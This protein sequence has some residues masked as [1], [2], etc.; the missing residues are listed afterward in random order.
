MNQRINDNLE[1]DIKAF[2]GATGSGKTYSMLKS[3]PTSARC[4]SFDPAGSVTGSGTGFV[5]TASRTEY[6]QMTR[7]GGNV[8]ACF[9]AA[10]KENF[11]WW[12]K[13][14]FALADARRIAYVQVDELSAVTSSSKAP[15]GWN[16]ILNLGRKYGLKVRAGAQRPQEIDK[17]LIGNQNGIWIGHQARRGDAE[18]LARETD[19]PVAEILALRK[20]PHF[21]HIMYEGR[22]NYKI[23][24]KAA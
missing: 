5:G 21:D 16:N 14:V 11:D 10:G 22:D 20:N 15:E 7:R 23:F 19:I 6:M 4:L 1:A 18:Y 2:F 13:W 8:R 12:C 17:T 3:I 9:Q 24:Q